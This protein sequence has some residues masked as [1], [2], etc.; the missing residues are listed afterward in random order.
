MSSD[1]WI[2][3]KVVHGKGFGKKLGFP[4]ANL[5]L[6]QGEERP[7]EGIYACWAKIG[8]EKFG[9]ALHV[10]PRPAISDETPTI[11]VHILDFDE[12]DLYGQTISL[13]LVQRLRDVQKFDSLQELAQAIAQDC[14]EAR[15]YL[16][17]S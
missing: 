14:N 12:R 15:T 2:S 10:G 4:T 7:A 1:T 5:E 9:G 6:I 17:A 3:G 13:Q 11:E 8:E 16:A